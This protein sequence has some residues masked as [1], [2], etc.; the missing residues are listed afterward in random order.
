[1]KAVY[2]AASWMGN[3]LVCLE[4]VEK[5]EVASFPM[6]NIPSIRHFPYAMI[7]TLMISN[8]W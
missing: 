1:M 8:E 3:L 7:V 2:E 4:L 5:V 6:V